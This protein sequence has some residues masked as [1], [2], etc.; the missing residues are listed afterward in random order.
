MPVAL[1][2]TD[3][4]ESILRDA[5]AKGC[6]VEHDKSAGTAKA[7]RNGDL[8]FQAIQ[9]GKGGPWIGRFINTEHITWTGT[10]TG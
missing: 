9:K 5:V 4:V 1:L 2:T 8:V 10:T 7:H 6:Y 3:R